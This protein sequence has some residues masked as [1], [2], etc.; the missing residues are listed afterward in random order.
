MSI[1]SFGLLFSGIIGLLL[2]SFV[3]LASYRLPR[4]EDII[5]KRSYCPSCN[6]GLGVWD[7]FPVLS[8]CLQSGHCRYCHTRIGWRY[9]AIEL[10][11]MGLCLVAYVHAGWSITLPI[12]Y[13]MMVCLALMMVVD[14]EHRILPDTVQVLC[15]C[16][17]I[18]YN[19]AEGISWT[20]MMQGAGMGLMTGMILRYGY[21]WVR[22]REGLGLGDVKFLITAGILLDPFSFVAFLLYSG[23]VGTLIGMIW[24]Y[25]KKEA[26]FPFAPALCLSLIA[27]L[28]FP[29][30][31]VIRLYEGLAHW[32]DYL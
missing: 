22:G 25:T 7:L 12:L 28:F 24:M 29:Q 4:G 9:P 11:V 23:V 8:W 16:L 18:G 2:G 32:I 19:Y 6:H 26:L 15:A 13:G 20:S 10:F 30:W 14:M 17:A 21:A 3:S 5:W 1:V 27:C 31:T